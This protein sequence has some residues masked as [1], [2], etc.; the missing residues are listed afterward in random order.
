MADGAR[1]SCFAFKTSGKLW[2]VAGLAEQSLHRDPASESHV[3]RLVDDAHGATADLT[4]DLVL[5][6]EDL[7]R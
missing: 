5:S 3:Q 4:N 7:S 2:V 6:L 1:G